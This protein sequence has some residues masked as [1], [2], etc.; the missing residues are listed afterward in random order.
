MPKTNE[1]LLKLDNFQYAMSLDLN[2]EYY[3]IQLRKNASN[4]CTMILLW[5]NIVKKVYQRWLLFT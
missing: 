2:M 1:M 4:L 5:G 3:N